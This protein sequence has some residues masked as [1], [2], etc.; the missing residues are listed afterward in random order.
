MQSA[1]LISERDRAKW[2]K[3]WDHKGQK[4]LNKYFQK[5][6]FIKNIKMADLTKNAISVKVSNRAKRAKFWDPKGIFSKI[7]NVM[8]NG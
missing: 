3:I 5:F 8:K 7:Q 6:N 4:S 2:T 1:D